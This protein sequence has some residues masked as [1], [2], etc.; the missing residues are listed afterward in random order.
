MH[1]LTHCVLKCFALN[2]SSLGRCEQDICIVVIQMQEEKRQGNP[3]LSDQ[4]TDIRTH[5]LGK[6]HF[7]NMFTPMKTTSGTSRV[8]AG[9][10]LVH[11]VS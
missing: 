9:C 10:Q 11:E 4:L 6:Q 3:S 8:H 5:Q 2:V 1:A 7:N